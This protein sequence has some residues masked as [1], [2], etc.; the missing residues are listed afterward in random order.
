LVQLT[1]YVLEVH[2]ASDLDAFQWDSIGGLVS[3]EMWNVTYYLLGVES[4]DDRPMEAFRALDA[5]TA[6]HWT[7]SIA[8]E[9]VDLAKDLLTYEATRYFCLCL[10]SHHLPDPS[11]DNLVKLPVVFELALEHFSLAQIFGGIWRCTKDAAAFTRRYPGAPLS[12]A[13]T[14]G[15]NRAGEYFSAAVDGDWDLMRFKARA[16]LPPLLVT[17][18]LFEILSLD[19]MNSNL[20][21]VEQ[22]GLTKGVVHRTQN[23]SE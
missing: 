19:L 10:E 3:Y 6:A 20:S 15:V 1:D 12:K 8:I 4:L 17:S 22:A 2:P 16:D 21:D 11:Q 5:V 13:T 14:H 23:A 18:E 9:A 7:S